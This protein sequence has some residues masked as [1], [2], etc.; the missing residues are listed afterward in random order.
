MST[1]RVTLPDGTINTILADETFVE[2]QYPGAW[3]L[4]PE[5]EPEQQPDSVPEQPAQRFV[6]RFAFR[7][8]FTTAEKI[9]LELASRDDPDAPGEMQQFAAA[10]RVYLQDIGCAECIDLDLPDTVE[11]VRMLETFGLLAPGRA[12]A[13]LLAPIQPAEAYTP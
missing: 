3:E 10:L 6:S 9:A 8:R 1:Y 13:I 4:V 2:D 7:R 11:G 5:A 12:D